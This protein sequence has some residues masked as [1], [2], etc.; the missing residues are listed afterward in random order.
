MPTWC[1]FEVNL[2]EMAD[3]PTSITQHQKIVIGPN[4]A[5]FVAVMQ[6]SQN[7]HAG[8]SNSSLTRSSRPKAGKS[9]ICAT[10]AYYD[11]RREMESGTTT[12]ENK[13]EPKCFVCILVGDQGA[14]SPSRRV[15]N[16]GRTEAIVSVNSGQQAQGWFHFKSRPTGIW[17][18]EP[19]RAKASENKREKAR[20][21][22]FV[23]VL[24]GD[25]GAA[26]PRRRVL[27][28][29]REQNVQK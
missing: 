25:Q 6:G 15:L 16:S 21:N 1:T 9:R 12:S 22:C 18:V 7:I 26:S 20:R 27:D 23:S 28:D 8:P 13:R 5:S 2:Q 14:A 24:V 11:L 3:H 19:P 4:L 17:K 29:K 10:L